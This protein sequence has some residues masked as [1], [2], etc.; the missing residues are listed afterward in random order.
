MLKPVVAGV[1][2]SNVWNESMLPRSLYNAAAI[3]VVPRVTSLEGLVVG[4][5]LA[6]TPRVSI[7]MQWMSADEIAGPPLQSDL[8]QFDLR[9]KF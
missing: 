7:G 1:I 6:L 8:F 3:R 4:G 9:A 2:A 5:S